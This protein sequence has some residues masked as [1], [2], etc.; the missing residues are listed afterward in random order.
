[1]RGSGNHTSTPGRDSD[2]GGVKVMRGMGAGKDGDA[3]GAIYRA[4]REWGEWEAKGE[5]W[6]IVELYK[7]FGFTKGKRWGGRF[8]GEMEA[9]WSTRLLATLEGGAVHG[10]A[11]TY[12]LRQWRLQLGCWEVRDD[13]SCADWATSC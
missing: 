12:S 6:L 11:V 8:N 4:G 2:Y 7:I 10:A 13:P 9:A 5:W 1:M 3:L